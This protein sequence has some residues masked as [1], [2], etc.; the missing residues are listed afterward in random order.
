MA[1][2][3]PA[4]H[5]PQ[6]SVDIENTIDYYLVE[7]PHMVEHFVDALENAI[8]HIQRS[9]GT[10]SPRYAVELNIPGLQFWTLANFPFSLFYME[11][12]DHLW[13][14][15]LVHMSRDIPPSLQAGVV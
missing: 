8:A 5:S 4:L 11:H 6:A 3:K 2:I 1:G 9:P 7:A 13:V 15:R 10:G 14:V 12:D